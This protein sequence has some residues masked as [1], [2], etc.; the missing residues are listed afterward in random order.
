M[1]STVGFWRVP[2]EPPS[3]L[4]MRRDTRD[5]DTDAVPDPPCSRRMRHRCVAMVERLGLTPPTVTDSPT[6]T[7]CHTG[8]SQR[9]SLMTNATQNRQRSTRIRDNCDHLR[10]TRETA[11][12]T[13]TRE[14]PP[15]Q[16]SRHTRPQLALRRQAEPGCVRQHRLLMHGH[17]TQAR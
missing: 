8:P 14:R 11:R 2:V 1:A 5:T 3:T 10:M 17:R 12:G 7:R 15:T 9:E 6:P 4:G 16:P 13:V